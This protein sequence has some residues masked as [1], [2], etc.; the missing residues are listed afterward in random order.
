MRKLAIVLLWILASAAI[1]GA[2][3]NINNGGGGGGVTSVTGTAPVQSSGGA[4]PAISLTTPFQQSI[5]PNQN[6]IYASPNCGTQPNCVTVY[7][8]GHS[9]GDATSNSTTTVTCPNSDCN[10]TGTDNLGRPI[11]SV[12]QLVW[13]TNNS[14]VGSLACAQ[15]TIKT[16]NGANSITL[17]SACGGNASGTGILIW[18]DDDST[19]LAAAGTAMG[20]ACTILWLPAGYMLT[21]E[22]QFISI[23][24]ACTT[25]SASTYQGPALKGQGITQTWIVPTPNF[26]ATTCTGQGIGVCFGATSFSEISDFSIW[27]G[28]YQR[29]NSGTTHVVMLV[30]GATRS[31][32]VD[33]E[34]WGAQEGNWTC[35]E[36]SGTSDLFELGGAIDCGKAISMLV[37]GTG[38][39][40]DNNYFAGAGVNLEVTAKNVTSIGNF[41][42]AS[43]TGAESV[44]VTSGG[45]LSEQ[46]DNV[47]SVNGASALRVDGTAWLRNSNIG[48]NVTG[49]TYGVFATSGAK[50]FAQNTTFGG[51]ATAGNL[52][53]ASGAT[54]TDQG[55]N[56][57]GTAG[58][59]TL[60]GAILNEYLSANLTLVTAAKLVLSAGWGSTAAWTSLSGGDFPIQ[61]T[62]TNSGTG[63]GASPTITYTFPTPLLVAPY[64]CTAVDPSGTNTL[65]T[66][67]TSSL[68]ATGVVF[69]FS[70]TPTVSDTELVQITCVTP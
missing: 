54:F 9:V 59:N 67:T 30:G 42:G 64:S 11:A 33:V 44:Y 28:G 34:G 4:T 47:S 52:D 15:T 37:G 63:Q 38:A 35:I 16:I 14:L 61:G 21:Q 32:N 25:L 26:D 40:L 41:V 55:S 69:T 46:N 5:A 27:G 53:I 29:T 19:N 8:D 6:A 1:V 50:V 51:G 20:N 66:F 17:N 43:N 36:V 60:T 48:S 23:P 24:S 62:I 18:G 39:F 70:L 3:T 68:T 58:T 31:R 57:Y 45:S 56:T 10:F 2:Q 12:G 65:G 13:M 22:A 49:T 7:D